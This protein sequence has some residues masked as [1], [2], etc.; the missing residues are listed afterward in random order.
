MFFGFNPLLIPVNRRALTMQLRQ[1]IHTARRFGF[2]VIELTCT[3]SMFDLGLSTI[4]GGEFT[5]ELV[6]ASDLRIHL[7]LFYGHHSLE[8]VALTDTHA[9]TRAIYLRRLL[10]V[11]DFF[12]CR[13]PVQLYVVHTGPRVYPLAEHLDALAKALEALRTIYPHVRIAVENGRRGS[14][15]EG[16]DEILALLKFHSEIPFVFDTSLAYQAV[17]FH[18]LAY[19]KLLKAVG[20]FEDQIVEVH[21]NNT[22]PGF[23]PNRPLHVPLEGGIDL[24]LAARQLRKNPH[25][26]HLIETLA[27]RDTEALIRDQRLLYRAL[28]AA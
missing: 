18:R 22:A 26:T 4:F 8:E 9:P 17:G 14:V 2:H 16:P 15:V 11:V 13:S 20:A 5:E 3:E 10:D 25:M 7:H 28:L 1:A 19:T 24:D 27:T 6:K 23:Q 12:E 21:W